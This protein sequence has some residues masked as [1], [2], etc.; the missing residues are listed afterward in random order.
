MT[1]ST[2]T[3]EIL[4]VPQLASYIGVS[5]SRAYQMIGLHDGPPFVRLPGR[6][7]RFRKVAVDNWLKEREVQ[8]ADDE[9]RLMDGRREGKK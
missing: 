1:P 7:R 9:R 4:D 8:C 5:R 2:Q 3:R 6:C